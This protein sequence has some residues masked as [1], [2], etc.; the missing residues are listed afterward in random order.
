MGNFSYTDFLFT[1]KPDIGW[2]PGGVVP[3][4]GWP[5]VFIYAA[6]FLGSL[7]VVRRSGL[8]EVLVMFKLRWSDFDKFVNRNPYVI[9]FLSGV[10][11]QP[12]AL[13]SVHDYPDSSQRQ[14]L[15]VHCLPWNSIRAG[16][17]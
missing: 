9:I 16:E 8:F 6:L 11:L 4:L 2:I 7:A 1:T 17:N 5:L 15:E 10:L 13:Y 12:L 3:V 14:V